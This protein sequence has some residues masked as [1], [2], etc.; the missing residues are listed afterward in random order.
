MY[1]NGVWEWLADWFGAYPS[2]P[3]IDPLGPSF[4]ESHVRHGGSWDDTKENVRAANR[5][6]F[7]GD[8]PDNYIGFR[9]AAV[10]P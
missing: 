2:E 5:G 3:L 9:C 7:Q 8:I 4:G 1:G 6:E 10:T